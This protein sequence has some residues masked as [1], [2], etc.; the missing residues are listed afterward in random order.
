LSR[1]VFAAVTW[2]RPPPD[3]AGLPLARAVQAAA[4]RAPDWRS[5]AIRLPIATTAPL[6]IAVDRGTGGQPQLRGTLTAAASS[7]EDR[8][9]AQPAAP[10]RLDHA[11]PARCRRQ[12][13]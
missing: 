12:R 1:R 5:L 11:P 7:D 6:S 4:A 3:P 10:Q 8:C 13:Q 2:F 9:V